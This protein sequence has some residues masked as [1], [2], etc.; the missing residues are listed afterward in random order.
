MIADSP[1]FAQASA[2]YRRSVS[3]S[4]SLGA[5]RRF[6]LRRS[7]SSVPPWFVEAAP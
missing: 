1:A 5:N 6:P 4:A 2:E 3:V 7:V